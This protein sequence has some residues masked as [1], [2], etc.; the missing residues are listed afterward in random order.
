M[1]GRRVFLCTA[2]AAVGGAAVSAQG[3]GVTGQYRV[4]GRNPD[5]SP[6]SG[7]ARVIQIG[8]RINITWEIAG[9]RFEGQG[10]VQGD[11]I[12]VD[13]GDATPVI[14]IVLDDGTLSGTWAAGRGSDVLTPIP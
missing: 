5:G 4:D 7:V 14:Y 12:T 8:D 1:I 2:L 11:E 9:R 3:L 10:V 13:W 6:Y